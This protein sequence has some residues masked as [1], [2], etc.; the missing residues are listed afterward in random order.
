ML[1]GVKAGV[2]VVLYDHRGALSALLSQVEGAISGLQVQRL[3]LLAP[4]LT[5]E[6]H[7]LDSETL[8]F[9]CLI[10]KWESM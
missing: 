7:V 8:L 9:I 2:I 10:N 4:G 1:N 3:G 6:V 5:E